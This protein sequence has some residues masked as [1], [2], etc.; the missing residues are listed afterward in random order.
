MRGHFDYLNDTCLQVLS[1]DRS[2][3]VAFDSPCTRERE[4]EG[5]QMD[6]WLVNGRTF[7]R[8]IKNPTYPAEYQV[9]C[10]S[11]GHDIDKR[12]V[13]PEWPGL[14]AGVKFDPTDKEILEHLA[15]QVGTDASQPHPFINEFIPT[16]PADD[17]ICCTHPE[18]L[19][20]IRRDGTSTHFFHRPTRAYTTGTRK[21]RK[22]HSRVDEGE[23]RWHK[24]GK[25]RAVLENKKQLGCKKI[26]VLYVSS[27]KKMK[28]EKTNWVMHQYH[29]GVDE[30][31]R[32]GELVVSKVFYQIQPRQAVATG[33]DNN[34]E[35]EQV[36]L[37]L[38]EE[39]S[40]ASS[41]VTS[42]SLTPAPC[43][44]GLLKAL[45]EDVNR[46]N[47]SIAQ[48]QVIAAFADP[49]EEKPGLSEINLE[50]EQPQVMCQDRQIDGAE[51]RA[52]ADAPQ[53]ELLREDNLP[54]L[55]SQPFSGSLDADLLKLLCNENLK[56][57]SQ[58]DGTSDW[59][60]IV[61]EAC[62]KLV[63]SQDAPS[64]DKIVLGTPPSD[65]LEYLFNS[66]GSTADWA[67]KLKLWSDSQKTEDFSL[68][69]FLQ[70][71]QPLP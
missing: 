41:G 48:K 39:Q 47:A 69:D 7:A 46:L 3:S 13:I 36:A 68:T 44:K 58:G 53:S 35:V 45:S 16:L 32:E 50:M 23:I 57:L 56:A 62:S 67:E 70:G 8:K 38:I 61:T 27:G 31:E 33:N 30:E 20:G 63:E 24:T 40:N 34:E 51:C 1:R 28:P 19:P 22:V 18:R 5:G 66:Q 15:A 71:S 11:C 55:G 25:T 59:K 52:S 17:G 12:E 43:N 49:V 21:R 65:F 42:V 29:L 64:L 14:P 10:P 4:R 2:S 37:E 60:S 6:S 9:Q 26:M 54:N